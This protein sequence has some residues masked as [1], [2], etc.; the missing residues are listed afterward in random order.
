[1]EEDD[2]ISFPDL[3]V[4]HLLA[5]DFDFLLRMGGSADHDLSSQQIDFITY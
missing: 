2:G 5:E 4:R 3:N 1:V